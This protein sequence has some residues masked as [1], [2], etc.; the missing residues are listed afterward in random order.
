MSYARSP[1]PVD[2][3]TIGTSIICGSF[4]FTFTLSTLQPGSRSRGGSGE[5]RNGPRFYTRTDGTENPG[6]FRCGFLSGFYPGPHPVSNERV[7]LQTSVLIVWPA[8]RVRDR[9]LHRRPGYF[10]P[11]PLFPGAAPLLH[12]ESPARVVPRADAAN[13]FS[14][15]ARQSGPAPPARAVP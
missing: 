7:Q 1:R 4:V 12:R 5:D 3:I 11:R 15:S 8:L 10:L 9:A 14:S 6:S 2:S 13:P